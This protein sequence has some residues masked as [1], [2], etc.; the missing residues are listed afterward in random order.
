MHRTPFLA[1][2]AAAALAFALSGCSTAGAGHVHDGQ[3]DAAAGGTHE[4][5][6][7]AMCAMHA[8]AQGS[9]AERHAMMEERM[10]AMPPEQRRR[11]QERMADCPR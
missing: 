3:A 2:A 11:M 7:H 10:R 8:G 6:M 9:S 1:A 4:G 5:G